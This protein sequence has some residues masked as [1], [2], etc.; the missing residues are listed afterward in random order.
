MSISITPAGTLPDYGDPDTFATR[1][2]ALFTWLTGT[3]IPELEA[4]DADDLN[5]GE[6]IN[7]ISVVV[8]QGSASDIAVAAFS[9]DPNCIITLNDNN[10]SSD[11]SVGIS[12]VGDNLHLRAGAANRVTV[13][14]NGNVG[15]G[16]GTPTNKLRVS[17]AA[18]S[19]T[20][21]IV[22]ND[23]VTQSTPTLMLDSATPASSSF[24]FMSAYS[25]AFG[26]LEFKL[27]GDGNG[28]CDGSW[29]G[30]G[31]DYAEYFEWVDGNIDGEDRRGFSVVLEADMI[32][33]AIDGEEPVGVIS[34]NPSV[35]GDGDIDRWK[36]KYLR[37][38][39]GAYIWE[40]YQVVEWTETVIE[41]IKVS[42]PVTGA[43]GKRQSVVVTKEIP[44]EEPRS[45]AAD[46]MPEGVTPPTDATCTTQQC[47]KLNPAYDPDREYISR[48]DRPEW[49]TVGLMG[50]LRLRKGQ[51]VGARWI[52]MRDISDTVEE[53]LVR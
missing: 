52:K 3:F 6:T 29:T 18:G 12:G 39:F 19:V 14:S 10:T 49:A 50:K 51:P 53:W 35:I 47:R 44:H 9:A 26:D 20:S 23:S 34:V 13:L 17:E 22:E 1:T 24:I 7:P 43:D 41:T 11:G 42:E 15:I 32:R 8:G 46:D 40:D 16:N 36:E 33:P 5:S 25:G 30:G 4:L 21:M 2:A 37:D 48:A 27:S 38:D 28:T 31:A 45:F